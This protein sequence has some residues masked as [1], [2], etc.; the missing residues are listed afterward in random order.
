[1]G[2]RRGSAVLWVR[3]MLKKDLER[4]NSLHRWL[5]FGKLEG[6]SLAGDFERQ[7]TIWTTPA[8]RPPRITHRKTLEK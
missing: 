2:L 1:M 6:G 4:G 8:L 5:R 3:D 7:A